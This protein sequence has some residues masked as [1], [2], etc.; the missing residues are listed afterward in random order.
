MVEALVAFVRKLHVSNS[1]TEI[2]NNCIL[3]RFNAMKKCVSLENMLNLTSE[4][5]EVLCTTVWPAL[6]TIGGKFS[7]SVKYNV[8]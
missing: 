2:V 5:L 1:W 6:V 3:E 4:N 7:I 8:L